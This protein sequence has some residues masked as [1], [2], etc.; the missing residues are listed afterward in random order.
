V[1]WESHNRE[2]VISPLWDLTASK[3]A[4]FGAVAF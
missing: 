4:G 3:L 2:E 1:F